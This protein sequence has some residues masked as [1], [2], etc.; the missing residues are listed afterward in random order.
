MKGKIRSYGDG[1]ADFHDR[2]I[3]EAGSS[4]ICGS[5]ILIGSVLKKDKNYYWQVLSKKYKCIEKEKN[6]I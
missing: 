1:A 3:S 5:I 6:S 2:K 4:Y